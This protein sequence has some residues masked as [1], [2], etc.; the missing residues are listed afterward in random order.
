MERTKKSDIKKRTKK[1]NKKYCGDSN[2]LPDGYHRF[3]TRSEC[4]RTGFGVGYYKKMDEIMKKIGISEQT[5]SKKK[6][7]EKM[8]KYFDKIFD[9]VLNELLEE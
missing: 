8:L 7:K 1:C 4:L 9:E 2:V 3:G 6:T 5:K